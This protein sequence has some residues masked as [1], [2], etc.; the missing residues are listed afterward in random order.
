VPPCAHGACVSLAHACTSR[1]PCFMRTC[2]PVSP[3]CC[4]ISAYAAHLS[5]PFGSAIRH[6][7]SGPGYTRPPRTCTAAAHSHLRLRRCV[8]LHACCSCVCAVLQGARRLGGSALAQAYG[9]VGDE[10]PDVVMRDVK[11]AFQTTQALLAQ[12]K[13][14]AGHDISDGGAVVAL[15]EMAFAGAAGIQVRRAHACNARMHA[16]HACDA[17]IRRRWTCRQTSGCRW[18]RR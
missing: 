16:T 17:C 4:R 12:G 5:A 14:L 6:R 1:A 3:R 7:R 2:M 10:T 13:L 11:A 9:Q 8:L 15:L 18:R